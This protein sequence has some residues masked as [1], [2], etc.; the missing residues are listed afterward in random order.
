MTQDQDL[1][2]GDIVLV[3]TSKI[4]TGFCS[5][6]QD[7]IRV[8]IEQINGDHALVTFNAFKDKTE[9]NLRDC[10]LF[11]GHRSFDIVYKKPFLLFMNKLN[12]IWK[13]WIKIF[14]KAR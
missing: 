3:D 12:K 2:P 5:M 14:F 6:S 10:T 8:Q 11:F 7:K 9:V 13:K 4:K 1:Q